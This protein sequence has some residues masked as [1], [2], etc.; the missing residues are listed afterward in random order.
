M[1]TINFILILLILVFSISCRL[2]NNIQ[3]TKI[4]F[5]DFKKSP[6]TNRPD[7]YNIYFNTNIKLDSALINSLI[8]CPLNKN[9]NFTV[10]N[11]RKSNNAISGFILENKKVNITEKTNTYIAEVAFKTSKNQGSETNFMEVKEIKKLLKN[12]T[13]VPCKIYKPFYLDSYKPYLSNPMCIP[14]K[15][16]LKVINE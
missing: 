1:K 3:E 10:E 14:V 11:L 9:I 15:D 7:L 5:L 2:D 6:T 13:C 12:L 16:I 8:Y 4:H